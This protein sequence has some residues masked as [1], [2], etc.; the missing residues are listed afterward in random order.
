[1]TTI[2]VL[3]VPNPMIIAPFLWIR[4]FSSIFPPSRDPPDTYGGFAAIRAVSGGG[5]LHFSPPHGPPR[6]VRW[7]PRDTYG[8]GEGGGKAFFCEKP[9]VLLGFLAFRQG[10]RGGGEIYPDPPQQTLQKVRKFYHLSYSPP[11]QTGFGYVRWVPLFYVRSAGGGEKCDLPLYP[12]FC[13]FF[14]FLTSASFAGELLQQ[15]VYFLF[16]WCRL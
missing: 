14:C 11:P 9:L 12:P 10:F 3:N 7:V 8:L 5:F 15:F 6:Y 4:G 2:R 13:K 16:L 1:M